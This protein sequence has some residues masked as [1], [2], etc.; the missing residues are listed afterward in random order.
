MVAYQHRPIDYHRRRKD[1][2]AWQSVGFSLYIA[3]TVLWRQLRPSLEALEAGTELTDQHELNLR[4]RG[5]FAML[6]GLCIENMLKS[7]IVQK[8]VEPAKTHDLTKLAHR[9]GIPWEQPRVATDILARLTTFVIWAG[10]YPVAATEQDTQ[11]PKVLQASDY[12][13]IVQITSLLQDIHLGRQPLP[14]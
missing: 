11:A 2:A 5:P 9:A 10:R 8:G 13:G 4:L 3:A 14:Q 12:L 7:V 6:S 1:P